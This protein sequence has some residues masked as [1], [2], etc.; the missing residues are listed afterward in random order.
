MANRHF[1]IPTATSSITARSAEAAPGESPLNRHK[2]IRERRLASGKDNFLQ[3]ELWKAA[4][5]H[6]IG[7]GDERKGFERR[8]VTLEN[9]SV[10]RW[11]LPEGD[12][13]DLLRAGCDLRQAIWYSDSPPDLR[14]ISAILELDW[15]RTDG[16]CLGFAMEVKG[17]RVVFLACKS[18][19][20]FETWQAALFNVIPESATHVRAHKRMMNCAK[21]LALETTYYRMSD[22]MIK[23]VVVECG[24]DRVTP[25]AP[26]ILY[27]D[28]CIN[29]IDI[30]TETASFALDVWIQLVWENE[31]LEGVNVSSSEGLD[32]FIRNEPEIEFLNMVHMERVYVDAANSRSIVTDPA[33][34]RT[35]CQ[36]VRRYSG[37]MKD[38]D[39]DIREF[40]F[41]SQDLEIELQIYG[42]PVQFK[43]Y[44]RTCRTVL[45]E[46]EDIRYT[47][48]PVIQMLEN[49][50]KNYI[51]ELHG[52]ES[53]RFDLIGARSEIIPEWYD[54]LGMHYSKVLLSFMIQRKWKFF[55]SR[56]FA[57]LNLVVLLSLLSLG[58]SVAEFEQRINLLVALFLAA[59]AFQFTIQGIIPSVGYM[60]KMDRYLM[61]TYGFI[62]ALGYEAV[63]VNRLFIEQNESLAEE[64]D[65]WCLY[66]FP[67][68][69]IVWK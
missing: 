8:Q 25:H 53:L 2:S 19:R 17:G 60:T 41:D 32:E 61:V 46:I 37:I 28:I 49:G 12:K 56:I 14:K 23:K 10:L 58:F 40:P 69:W 5:F 54:F 65:Q 16:D 33:D 11:Y 6:G 38:L 1:S 29:N 20:D 39:M 18:V 27:L 21:H 3:G 36:C 44:R 43:D 42:C 9:D 26:N 64:I 52:L 13:Q 67:A 45:C 57:L 47:K 66:V 15:P 35:Y 68:I 30:M 55:R 63:A 62:S 31:L 34:G 51:S 50:Q 48:Q 7:G 24:P 4:G 59:V 22:E